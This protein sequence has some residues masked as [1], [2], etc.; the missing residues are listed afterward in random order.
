MPR[1]SNAS[2]VEGAEVGLGWSEPV[3]VDSEGRLGLSLLP[4]ESALGRRGARS[5]EFVSDLRRSRDD[6]CCESESISDMTRS[7]ALS[8]SLTHSSAGESGGGGA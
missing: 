1:V 2:G 8:M 5:S 6:C 4:N 3:E 7:I